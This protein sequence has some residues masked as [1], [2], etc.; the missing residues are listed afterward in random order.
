M[1]KNNYGDKITA[2][3]NSGYI[4]G[5]RVTGGTEG[6]A[7]S[8]LK[9][10]SIS[11]CI[12]KNKNDVELL[13]LTTFKY[14][15]PGPKFKYKAFECELI[16][17]GPILA[18]SFKLFSPNVAILTRLK[19]RDIDQFLKLCDQYKQI[20]EA[21]K[22]IECPP[23]KGDQLTLY[24][25]NT[26]QTFFNV[27]KPAEVARFAFNSWH[28]LNNCE[29][30]PLKINDLFE[31]VENNQSLIKSIPEPGA[32]VDNNAFNERIQ[33][34]E[35][36]KKYEFI[37]HNN[38]M[39]RYIDGVYQEID[40]S[41][42]RNIIGDEIEAYN[43]KFATNRRIS[44]VFALMSDL[45]PK[46]TEQT[47]NFINLTNGLYDIYKD[48]LIPHNKNVISFNRIPI[49]YDEAATCP[50]WDNFLNYAF[51]S[52]KET[53]QALQVYF[54]YCLV[55]ECSQQKGL[56]LYGA[57]RTGKSTIAEILTA[58]IGLENTATLSMEDLTG[59]Y[60]L[61]ACLNAR[62]IWVDE[63]EANRFKKEDE[64]FLKKL[65]GNSIQQFRG[66]YWKNYIQ[67][68]LDA[69]FIATANIFP[70]ISDK[71]AGLAN[72]F[73]PFLFKNVI[74]E[75]DPFFVKSLIDN[76]LPGIFN[77]ALRG[78]EMY[79]EKRTL[80]IPDRSK[81]IMESH[82]IESNPIFDMFSIVQQD[83][84]HKNF[85]L[86]VGEGGEIEINEMFKIYTRF[87][88][89]EGSTFKLTKHLLSRDLRSIF[90]EKDVERRVSNGKTYLTN[91][92]KVYI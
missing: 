81:K 2:G 43:V 55:P 5:L 15:T 92:K 71:S 89:D 6:T 38:I 70:L 39:H 72:R 53:I 79:L 58:V 45:M 4:Y 50:T 65:I 60:G 25:E 10:L 73:I 21:I 20:P 30:D 19:K 11:T 33:A 18:K 62:L 27:Y 82:R 69:K 63:I 36:Q 77:W 49:I 47:P 1:S 74:K 85:K 78:V 34:R 61:Q 24:C 29:F 14:K 35:I 31:A 48:K 13:I 7:K 54:G 91:I 17:S 23:V 83:L 59:P 88:D 42:V 68:R 64:A 87:M 40:D 37:K 67:M 12:I 80:I 84:D 46:I 86:V 66:A 90:I 52:D 8:I 16:T 75:Q 32:G 76:E 56:W 51:N 28:K 3:L 41:Y 22:K 9:S 57:S 44:S 26:Y